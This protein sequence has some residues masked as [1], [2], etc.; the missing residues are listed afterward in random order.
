MLT[1]YKAGDVIVEE[2][3]FGETAYVI[4]EGQVEVTKESDGQ[5][6]HLAYL[7]AKETF[8]EMSMIDEKPRSATVT[9]VTETLVSEVRRDDF[10]SSLQTDPNGVLQLLKV[11]FERLREADATI[12]QFQTTAPRDALLPTKSAGVARPS[13]QLAITLEGLTPRAAAAL[14]VT[15]FQITP[16]PFRIGRRSPDPLVYNDLML[17]DSERWKSLVII[18]PLSQMKAG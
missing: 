8:G 2:H 4:L 18:L 3:E 1:R 15:P 7:G 5:S 12:A 6:I 17:P 13:G 16:F 9:A 14:P 11:L 10:F